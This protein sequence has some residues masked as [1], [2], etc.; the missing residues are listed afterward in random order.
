MREFESLV[1]R[2]KE[3]ASTQVGAFSFYVMYRFELEHLRA[4]SATAAGGGRREHDN[5]AAVE[6]MRS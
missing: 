5:G 1:L 2:Q 3:E 6:I 4:L